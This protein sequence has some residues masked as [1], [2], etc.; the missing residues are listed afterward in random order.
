[1][2]KIQLQV[3]QPEVQTPSQVSHS[4]IVPYITTIEQADEFDLKY[5]CVSEYAEETVKKNFQTI[6]NELFCLFGIWFPYI[7]NNSER[8][9]RKEARKLYIDKLIES[10]IVLQY[11]YYS[12]ALVKVIVSWKGEISDFRV[13]SNKQKTVRKAYEALLGKLNFWPISDRP[14]HYSIP[15]SVVTTN[16]EPGIE[17]KL[18]YLLEPGNFK[19]TR[20]EL[21]TLFG[22]WCSSNDV[23]LYEDVC[24]HYVNELN[25][26]NAK[27]EYT[28]DKHNKLLMVKVSWRE[29]SAEC[30]VVAGKRKAARNAFIALL[31]KLKLWPI[32]ECPDVMPNCKMVPI[33]PI[34]E[35]INLEKISSSDSLATGS[36]RKKEISTTS[37]QVVG[38][39]AS[40]SYNLE[41]GS[42]REKEISVTS[43]QIEGKQVSSD[44]ISIDTI[45][46]F[47]AYKQYVYQKTNI[48]YRE[49]VLKQLYIL[50]NLIH[51]PKT[52]IKITKK[53]ESNDNCILGFQEIEV[54]QPEFY[55]M[56]LNI[57]EEFTKNNTLNKTSKNLTWPVYD[58]LRQICV[59]PVKHTRGPQEYDP[60]PKVFMYSTRYAFDKNKCISIRHLYEVKRKPKSKP[61]SISRSIP[62]PAPAPAPVF[63]SFGSANAYVPMPVPSPVSVPVPVPVPVSVSVPVSVP[64]A[65][66]LPLSV[67]S[68]VYVP[69]S[70]SANANAN[71]NAPTSATIQSQKETIESSL[72][73]V[74]PSVQNDFHYKIG[75]MLKNVRN[76]TTQN[77]TSELVS[78]HPVPTS[79]PKVSDSEAEE[80]LI[81]KLKAMRTKLEHYQ[82][83]EAEYK[84]AK[85]REKARE[86]ERTK[87]KAMQAKLETMRAKLE[88]YKKTEE[89]EAQSQSD[90][91]TKQKRVRDSLSGSEYSTV[92]ERDSRTSITGC[93]YNKKNKTTT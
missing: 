3:D 81:A 54:K 28:L 7:D 71:A 16:I 2:S 53:E 57:I 80:A 9:H 19:S 35:P 17:L 24:E 8:Q 75:I 79:P 77:K 64:S 31:K 68:P 5:L 85:A 83:K 55:T 48:N 87:F 63:V 10:K 72:E 22:V 78:A 73:T 49:S 74:H 42:S 18:E 41:T 70:V 34:T 51:S 58:L 21:F 23:K 84:A 39:Q 91:I 62:V 52:S 30:I 14:M 69:V 67:P 11:E 36:C 56:I 40:S 38:K 29:E 37:I 47:I 61:I 90:I 46:N 20:K 6:R 26:T 27:I 1:M 4:K 88:Q 93:T 44:N 12:T 50:F 65:V 59:S 32:P 25:K 86:E 60:G 13:V 66:Y 33:Y 92:S 15:T 89:K 82:K 45:Q 43:M 76:E